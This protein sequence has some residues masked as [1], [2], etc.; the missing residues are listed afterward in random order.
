MVKSG[1]Y[2][3]IVLSNNKVSHERDASKDLLKTFRSAQS[4]IAVYLRYHEERTMTSFLSHLY[5]N[6][7]GALFPVFL[8]AHLNLLVGTVDFTK[9]ANAVHKFMVNIVMYC[10][11]LT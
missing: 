11:D 2:A 4:Q 9:R 6:I 7:A 1:A 10:I 5:F 3:G 8:T